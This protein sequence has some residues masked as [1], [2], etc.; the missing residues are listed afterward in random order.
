M[1][2]LENLLNYLI[3][4]GWKP[5]E[6][7]WITNAVYDCGKIVFRQNGKYSFSFSIRELVSLESELWSFVCK[8]GLLAKSVDAKDYVEDSFG[9]RRCV[10][11]SNGMYWI[12]QSS[13]YSQRWLP[14]FLVDNISI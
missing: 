4:K 7:D 3:K 11:D 9:F 12:M 8:N 14:K 6:L 1:K 2:E 10:F 13:L 5:F